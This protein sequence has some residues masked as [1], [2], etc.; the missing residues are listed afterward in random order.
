MKTR[1]KK[2]QEERAAYALRMKQIVTKASEEKRGLDET[3][4]KDWD[5]LSA[6]VEDLDGQIETIERALS[7]EVEERSEHDPLNPENN[8]DNGENRGEILTDEQR[9]NQAFQNWY[10]SHTD[11]DLMTAE[12][13][14][15]MMERRAQSTG[16]DSA[17]GYTVPEGFVNAIESA[18]L[19]Y[20]GLMNHV[21]IMPTDTGQDLPFPTDNDTGQEGE[22]VGE[23]AAVSEQD[24]AFGVMML[25]AYKYSSKLI[26]V[27]VELLQD[28]AFNMDNYLSGKLAERLWRVMSRHI[29]VGTGT[30]QPNGIVTAAPLGA[31]AAAVGAIALDDMTDLKHSVDIAYREGGRGKWGFNDQTLKLIK[32]LKDSQG[33]PLWQPRIDQDSP[34]TFDGDQYVI[35]NAIAQVGTGNRSVIYGDLKKY[36]FRQVKGVTM[37]KL[38]E[39]YAEFHQVGFLGFMRA[40]GDLL[41]A[42]TGPVKHLVH[43]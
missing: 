27:P 18:M 8:P 31:T 19:G 14:S 9:H 7:L 35:D 20:G 21:D 5:E 4:S 40:D 26:R 3:E 25:K 6:K 43:P 38:V 32:Q 10:R 15:L 30:N 37:L 24:V 1:L 29:A 12:D 22:I 13:R 42:G 23:N 33:L 39:R 17:G 2:L 36:K 28:S 34:A 16:T 41:D 11:Y